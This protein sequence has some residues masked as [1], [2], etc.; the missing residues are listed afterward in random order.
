MF[1]RSQ[2]V[3]A[4]ITSS[5]LPANSTPTD[6]YDALYEDRTALL[7][8]GELLRTARLSEFDRGMFSSALSADKM[9]EERQHGLARLLNLCLESQQRILDSYLEQYQNGVRTAATP[10]RIGG[11]V[12]Q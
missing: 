3:S 10:V 7:T 12:A 5:K 6:L 8:L 1:D 2:E 11:E 9:A 4:S